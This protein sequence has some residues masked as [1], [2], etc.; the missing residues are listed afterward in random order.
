[1][2]ACWRGHDDIVQTARGGITI[3]APKLIADRCIQAQEEKAKHEEAEATGTDIIALT[4]SLLVLY[5]K[6]EVIAQLSETEKQKEL[7]LEKE[8]LQKLVDQEV[9][10]YS[11][12][13]T[14]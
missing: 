13:K 10:H 4:K 3:W 8:N 2:R 11:K 7:N 14:L 9:W 5:R 6:R 1:M 12:S